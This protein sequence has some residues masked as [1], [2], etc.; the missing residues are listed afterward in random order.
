MNI[1]LALQ[2]KLLLGLH[3]FLSGAPVLTVNPPLP[4]ALGNAPPTHTP[5]PAAARYNTA[6]TKRRPADKVMPLRVLRVVDSAMPRSSVGR[7]VIS[8]RMADVCA[9]LDRMVERESALH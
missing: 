3:R 4:R 8:G 1:A 5:C 9:A 7:L 2:Q 6:L